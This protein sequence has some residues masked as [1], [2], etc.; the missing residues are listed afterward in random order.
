MATVTIDDLRCWIPET[1]RNRHTIRNCGCLFSINFFSFLFDQTLNHKWLFSTFSVPLN[2][3]QFFNNNKNITVIS[4]LTT[5]WRQNAN[6]SNQFS[7]KSINF[8]CFNLRFYY[9]WSIFNFE[10]TQ[11]LRSE[12]I[13]HFW[14]FQ[15]FPHVFT[16][17]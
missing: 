13:V 16:N 10:Q 2:W 11:A 17:T 9:F 1:Y 4:K 5:C 3:F 12:M 14:Y 15:Q 8:F 7:Q 6:I